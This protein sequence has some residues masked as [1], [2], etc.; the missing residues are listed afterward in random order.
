MRLL[1]TACALMLATSI[2]TVSAQDSPTYDTPLGIAM[3]SYEYPFPVQFLPLT[4][5][6]ENVRMAYMDV[7]PGA[8][9]STSTVVLLHGKNFYGS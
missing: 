3:E 2:S 7:K 5:E 4:I 1:Q 8:D 6:G 9:Q